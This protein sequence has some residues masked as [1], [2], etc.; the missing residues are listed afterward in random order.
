MMLNTDS[1]ALNNFLFEGFDVDDTP[2]HNNIDYINDAILICGKM[3]VGVEFW[4]PEEL[5]KQLDQMNMY[6]VDTLTQL[7]GIQED[8]KDVIAEHFNRKQ[9]CKSETATPR[10]R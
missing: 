2:L 8:F 5:R 9:Q 10:R 1:Q 4:S 6:L 3:R 7:E